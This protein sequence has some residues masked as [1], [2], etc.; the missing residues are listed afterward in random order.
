MIVRYTGYTEQEI[1]ANHQWKLAAIIH[2]KLKIFFPGLN[3]GLKAIY[4]NKWVLFY[5]FFSCFIYFTN[6]DL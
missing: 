6:L 3:L 4:F 2:I 5:E 1:K